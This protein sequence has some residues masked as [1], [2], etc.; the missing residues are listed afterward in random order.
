[1]SASQFP[2]V[3]TQ[4]VTSPL[5]MMLEALAKRAGLWALTAWR[6]AVLTM[7]DIVDKKVVGGGVGFGGCGSDCKYASYL[8]EG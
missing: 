3:R 7:G 1:M 8:A 4:R 5:D 6:A 2:K